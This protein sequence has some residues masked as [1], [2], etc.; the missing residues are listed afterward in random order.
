MPVVLTVVLVKEVPT[1]SSEMRGTVSMPLVTMVVLVKE[2]F[3]RS[4]TMSGI[5]NAC[6]CDGSA[7]QGSTYQVI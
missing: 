5:P 6:D 4:S 1:R 7:G 3:T 2:V